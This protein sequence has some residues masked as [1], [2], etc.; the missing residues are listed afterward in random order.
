MQNHSSALNFPD[1]ITLSLRK[2]MN[3]LV[4]CRAHNIESEKVP[5]ML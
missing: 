4:D 3:A 5:N 2:E 1:D